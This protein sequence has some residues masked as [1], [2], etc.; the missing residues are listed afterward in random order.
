M[1]PAGSHGAHF[2]NANSSTFTDANASSLPV[3]TRGLPW[4][5]QSNF[6]LDNNAAVSS[7]APAIALVDLGYQDTTSY[8]EFSSTSTYGGLAWWG[9]EDGSSYYVAVP[10]YTKTTSTTGSCPTTVIIGTCNSSIT[11]CPPPYSTT[12]Q[13]S[14]YCSGC[15]SP[16]SFSQTSKTI[17]C[18]YPGQTHAIGGCT[19]TCTT[20]DVT[21]QSIVRTCYTVSCSQTVTCPT[22]T[23]TGS[24]CIPTGCTCGVNYTTSCTGPASTCSGAGC[25]PN[26]CCGTVGT[27]G[28]AITSFTANTAY[29]RSPDTYE[30]EIPGGAVFYVEFIYDSTLT[31]LNLYKSKVTKLESGLGYSTSDEFTLDEVIAYSSPT[32]TTAQDG[33]ITI[34][35]T[36]VSSGSSGSTSI[37]Y[38]TTNSYKTGIKIFRY[39]SGAFTLLSSPIVE[40][41]SSAYQYARAIR[42]VTSGKSATVTLFGGVG[43]TN[44]LGS[45]TYS[46]NAIVLDTS[47]GIARPLGIGSSTS[48][49]DNY[50][51]DTGTK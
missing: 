47:V 27:P 37:T 22:N 39:A 43:A 45:T 51:V 14:C 44:S 3:S 49:L 30:I 1:I 31:G 28:G 35:V 15:V 32:A 9:K 50:T 48:V 8:V 33:A 16:C 36:G 40:T 20:G 29:S 21:G 11:T 34:D 10:Y 4:D 18:N 19:Y 26:S 7:T 38:T 13:S 6:A 41:S 46:N 24:G 17:I 12:T 42:V 2:F 5:V 25:I 23:C